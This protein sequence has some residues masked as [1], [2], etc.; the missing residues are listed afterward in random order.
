MGV[1]INNR[2]YAWGDIAILLDGQPVAGARGINYKVSQNK[3]ALMAAGR[4][5][6]AI[7]K[8]SRSYEGSLT[9]LQS[10]LMALNRRARL[11]GYKD[12][13][14]ADI[15]LIVSYSINGVAMMV[16]RLNCVNF[17]EYSIDA[18]T[19]TMFLEIELPFI[20]LDAEME[21]GF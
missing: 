16:D 14:G 5:P 13:L 6:R 19:D 2:E 17:S 3:E 10:E 18:S 15:S 20:A 11:A 4:E 12:L 1:K 7:Q 21:V 8:G 9:V